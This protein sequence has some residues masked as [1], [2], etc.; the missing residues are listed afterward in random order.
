MRQF[1]LP[2]DRVPRIMQLTPVLEDQSQGIR[3][4]IG[5]QRQLVGILCTLQDLGQAGQLQNIEISAF[6]HK[7]NAPAASWTH[8]DTQGD[9]S[10][11]SVMGKLVGFEFD[12]DERYVGVVHRLEGLLDGVEWRI[13]VRGG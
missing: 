3:I 12:G 8:T 10:I 9:I 1:K 2:S 7:L 6:H 13:E 4:V 11:T 5:L